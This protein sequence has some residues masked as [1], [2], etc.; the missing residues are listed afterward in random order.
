MLDK[1]FSL[2]KVRKALR[3]TVEQPLAQELDRQLFEIFQRD[4]T[5][6][7]QLYISQKLYILCCF[8]TLSLDKEQTQYKKLI[9]SQH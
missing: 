7:I 2:R 1:F 9:D 6:N 8:L 5:T 3:S 4:N